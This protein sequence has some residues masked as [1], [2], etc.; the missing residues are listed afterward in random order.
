MEH[1]GEI[2][3]PLMRNLEKRREHQGC[4][5]WFKNMILAPQ[6][7]KNRRNYLKSRESIFS[8]DGCQTTFFFTMS[9]KTLSV[10]RNENLRRAIVISP[11]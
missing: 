6:D 2:L 3:K 1:I 9:K 8:K 4:E 7:E 5:R 11:A 10:E